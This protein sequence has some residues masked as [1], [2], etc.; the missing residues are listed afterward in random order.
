M[1]DT[2]ITVDSKRVKST[3]R[4]SQKWGLLLGTPLSEAS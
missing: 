3:A 2:F 4:A 1:M